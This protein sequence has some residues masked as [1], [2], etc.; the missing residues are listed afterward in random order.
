VYCECSKTG[1]Q[2]SIERKGSDD[3]MS[4]IYQSETCSQAYEREYK[5][6]FD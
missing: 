5:L 2:T 3:Y 4:W 6:C 1:V